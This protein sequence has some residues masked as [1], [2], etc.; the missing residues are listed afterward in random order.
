MAKEILALAI[1]EPHLGKSEE[2]AAVL[3]Q[4]YDLLKKK[5]YSSDL[6]FREVKQEGQERWVHLRIWNSL[7][8]RTEAMQ[9]PEVHRFWI[10][11]PD[12]C[13]ITTI[14][15]HLEEMYS[16]YDPTPRGTSA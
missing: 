13:K 1:L 10:Q 3:Q 11:L 7:E 4:L 2:C 16:S 6:L 9:D 8:A 15:E 5:G 12:V 14:F